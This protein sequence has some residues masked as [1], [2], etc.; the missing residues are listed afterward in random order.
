MGLVRL[1][2]HCRNFGVRNGQV[3]LGWPLVEHDFLVSGWPYDSKQGLEKVWLDTNAC[4]TKCFARATMLFQ[5][6][7]VSSL[8]CV[9]SV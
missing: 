4:L 3:L 2:V 7:S 9:E 1:F 8:L 5:C 6:V